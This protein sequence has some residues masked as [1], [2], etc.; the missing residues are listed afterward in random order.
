M[1]AVSLFKGVVDSPLLIPSIIFISLVSFVVQKYV[2]YRRLA[3]FRGPFWA[4]F[5]ELWVV[6]VTFQSRVHTA[7]RE[8]S[9]TYG[10]GFLRL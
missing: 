8:L 9:E 6:R 7:M 4:S 2:V 1:A 5:T 3:Q 10:T